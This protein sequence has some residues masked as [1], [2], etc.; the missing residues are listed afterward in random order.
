MNN[1]VVPHAAETRR[2]A[3]GDTVTTRLVY[4]TLFGWC[5]DITVEVLSPKDFNKPGRVWPGRAAADF[6]SSA[7]PVSGDTVLW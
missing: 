7:R 4:Q 3:M 1:R 6:S 5:E 2:T